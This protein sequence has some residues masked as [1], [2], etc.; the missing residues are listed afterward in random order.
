MA[1]A[2]AA[3]SAD[4]GQPVEAIVMDL[5]HPEA[6]PA[7][8]PEA[9]DKMDGLDRTCSDP[10]VETLKQSS[11][12][13][14][15]Q[16]QRKP[17]RSENDVVFLDTHEGVRGPLG[18]AG[19]LL[20]MLD[21]SGVIRTIDWTGC[22]VLGYAQDEIVGR[23]WFDDMLPDGVRE[24]A[25]SDFLGVLEDQPLHREPVEIPVL[26]KTGEI[27]VIRWRNAR[28]VDEQGTPTAVLCSGE[29]VSYRKLVEEER[30][31]SVEELRNFFECA[32]IGMAIASMDGTL[33]KVNATLCEMLGYSKQELVGNALEHITY[34]E[35]YGKDRDDLRQVVLGEADSIR[36]EHRYIHKDGRVLWGS[37][38]LSVV[39]DGEGSPSSLAVQIQE[40]TQRKRSEQIR[41]ALHQITAAVLTSDSLSDLF[42]AIRRELGTVIDTENLYVALYDDETDMISL[43]YIANQKDAFREFPAGNSLT[44]HVI[45]T[46]SPLLVREKQIVEMASS[47]EIKRV[48]APAKVWLGVPLKIGD[49]VIGSLALQSYAD[50][51]TYDDKDLSVLTFVSDQVALAIERKRTEDEMRNRAARLAVVTQTAKAVTAVL[52]LDELMETVYLTTAPIFRAD[53]F[54]IAF[55]DEEADELDFRFVVDEGIRQRPHRWAMAGTLSSVVVKERRV[56]HVRDWDQEKDLLPKGSV[57]GKG[58]RPRSWLGIP[59]IV[60]ERLI[61]ILNVQSFRP[62]AYSEEEEKLLATI[63]DQ[64]AVAFENA[65]LY[66]GIRQELIERQ[67]SEGEVRKLNQYLESIIDDAD[68]WLEV[69][70]MEGKILLWNKAAEEISGYSRGE[71]LGHAEVWEWIYPS[72]ANRMNAAI[73]SVSSCNHASMNDETIIRSKDGG[74]KTIAWNERCLLDDEGNTAGIIAIGRDVTAKKEAAAKLRKT[75]DGTIEAIALTTE[76]R[77]PY[78]SG[79]QKRVA[80][81]SVAIAEELGLSKER[82]EGI[83]VAGLTH[84]IGKL[85]VPSEILNK[86]RALVNAEFDLVKGHPKAAHDILEPI[87]LP[88]PV[89]EI[90]LQH[91]ERMD[92]SGYPRGLEGEEILLEARILAVADVV[93]AMLSHRPYRPAHDTE[94]SLAEIRNGA[95]IQYDEN[96][97]NACVEL[98]NS[99]RFAFTE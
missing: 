97:V 88:W 57:F 25:L 75:L 38:N 80:Q 32:S 67:R 49:R 8:L 81:L 63:G 2:G 20:L 15:S 50:A 44:A 12:Q 51:M 77:D 86:P 85:A 7:T 37:L 73:R 13:P 16:P 43:P 39:R 66:E 26:T 45:R 94:Q 89:A 42:V 52:R 27:R 4:D 98:F 68:V 95:G 31:R 53:T 90:V 21:P 91:H 1:V 19:V 82:C 18:A 92:G 54:F 3:H 96:V 17:G 14:V 59:L 74:D 79:H 40:I 87:D 56:L 35:D 46:E 29:D 34:P 11:S 99:D 24:K 28:I 22:Q 48:G 61:G 9:I 65:R 76:M 47:G 64:I 23:N 33:R 60:G 58:R 70:D 55:V 41:E 10:A 78:T 69:F 6:P 71:V 93:E 84:D 36:K 62:N 83:R 30:Q 72:E 5:T